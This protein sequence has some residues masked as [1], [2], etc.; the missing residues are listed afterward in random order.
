MTKLHRVRFL[1]FAL[2][3]LL[4]AA[5]LAQGPAFAQDGIRWQPFASGTQTAKAEKKKLMIHF[6]A[7]WCTYCKKMESE[8]FRNPKVV[9]ALNGQFV[10]VRVDS[11]R[12]KQIAGQFRVRGLPDTWFI[13]EDGTPIGNRIG[14]ISADQL[15]KILRSIK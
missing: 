5:P 9:E 12:E 6:Y 2:A 7:D 3:A 8:T 13:G 15:L 14:F 11:G 10:T 4:W 1:L